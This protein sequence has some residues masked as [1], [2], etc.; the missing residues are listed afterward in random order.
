MKRKYGPDFLEKYVVDPAKKTERPAAPDDVVNDLKRKL[1][2]I[3]N[4]IF[5]LFNPYQ[6]PLGSG[7]SDG[8]VEAMRHLNEVAFYGRF[9]CFVS[10]FI[11][12]V[13]TVY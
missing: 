6:M 1:V 3:F 11:G 13:A 8:P 5:V 7:T 12:L 9:L 10:V 4:D 2:A